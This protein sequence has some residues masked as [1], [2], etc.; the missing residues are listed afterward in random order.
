MNP[1][2][3][4]ITGIEELA[5][6]CPPKWMGRAYTCWD[7]DR[8]LYVIMPANV[9]LAWW[10]ACYFGLRNLKPT[11]WEERLKASYRKGYEAGSEAGQ[12]EGY[13]NCMRDS[14]ALSFTNSSRKISEN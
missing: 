10:V 2:W 1:L 9:F 6:T 11:H 5:G 13:R 7:Y 14:K 4:T 12:R 8:V 3:R